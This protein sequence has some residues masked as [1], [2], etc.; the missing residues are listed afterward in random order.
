MTKATPDPVGGTYEKDARGELSGRVTDSAI[1]YLNRFGDRMVYSPAEQERRALTGFEFISKKFAEFGVTSVSYD[2]AGG[3][4]S[5]MSYVSMARDRGNLHTRISYDVGPDVLEAMIKGGV[6]SGFGDEWF[7][8]GGAAEHTEDGGLSSRTMSMT[9]PYIGVT[10]P[11][12]G[13]LIESQEEANAWAERVHRAGI[14]MNMHVNGEPA[15]ERALVAYERAL[16]MLP[17]PNARPKFTHCSLP[18]TEQIRRIKA[19]DGQPSLF[20]TYIYYNADKF[21]YYGADLAEHMMPYRDMID[22]GVN[23]STGSDFY[24][25]PFDPRMAIQGMVTRKGFNGETWGASQRVSVDEAIRV[26]TVNG[27]Y[28]TFEEHLKGTIS[29]GKLA[30]FVVLSDDLYAMDPAKI[31]DAKV[32]QTVVGGVTRY[33]A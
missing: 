32:V 33:Q 17:S 12:T 3:G 30:D 24:P 27:A 18:S 1:A 14:R 4:G 20:N 28:S 25:G 23:V 21:R 31:I 10:P 8:F 15:I 26:S 13:N 19:M 9:R 11:Y 2:G 5:V 29:P 7:R 22:A 6:R 16:S